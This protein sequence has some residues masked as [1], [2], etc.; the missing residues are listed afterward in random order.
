M[1]AYATSQDWLEA[2]EAQSFIGDLDGDGV[3]DTTKIDRALQS[4][5]DEMNGWLAKRYMTPVFDPASAGVL[6]V[7]AIAMG[8]YHLARTANALTEE[9]TKR[10]EASISYL[11]SVSKGDAD[12]PVTPSGS[13]NETGSA[14]NSEVQMVAPERHFSRS[15]FS[16]W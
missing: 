4:A 6:K 15:D 16:E 10:Y 2:E 5:S 12:L 7:H 8:T 14:S 9:I 1:S 11:K 13:D 3:A